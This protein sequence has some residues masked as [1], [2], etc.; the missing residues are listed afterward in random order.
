MIDNN[1]VRA[2]FKISVK[3]QLDGYMVSITD[4]GKGL[5][6][7]EKT[8]VWNKYYKKE[9][10]HKR[11]VVGSGIGLSIVKNVLEQHKFPYGIDSK[12]NQYTTFYFKIKK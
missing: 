1:A 11:N 12:L 6:E 2:T 5:T 9:K 4:T 7:K 3:K 8:L 10:K